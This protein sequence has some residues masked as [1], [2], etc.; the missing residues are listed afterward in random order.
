MASG[1]VT[2]RE[3]FSKWKNKTAEQQYMDNFM[4]FAECIKNHVK[5]YTYGNYDK[6]NCFKSMQATIDKFDAAQ[7]KLLAEIEKDLNKEVE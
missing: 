2:E 3:R 1:Y 6:D 7:E 4:E 5:A